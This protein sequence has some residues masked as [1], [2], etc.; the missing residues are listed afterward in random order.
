MEDNNFPLTTVEKSIPLTPVFT[1]NKQLDSNHKHNYLHVG[2][3]LICACGKKKLFLEPS[4]NQGVLTGTKSDGKSYSVRQSRMRYMFPGEW[5]KF[6]ATFTN[7]KHLL[8]FL[9]SIY[10]G[11][12][13]MEI[14]HLKPSSFNFERGTV[15]FKVIKQR[16]AKKQYYATKTG[17]QF[18]VSD[19]FL[20]KVK[21]Y[22]VKY[23]VDDNDYLFLPKDK[24]PPH[25]ET[26]TNAQKKKYYET[27][28][29]GYS[30]MFKR[31]LRKA[32]IKSPEEL[33]L[34]NLRKTYG[35]YMRA[36]GMALAE[37]C[38]RMG[39]DMDTFMAHYGSSLI[40]TREE[41]GMIQKMY[42][43]VR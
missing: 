20:K 23:K 2:D 27:T 41:I 3:Y 28:K 12:R 11:G 31:R 8:F 42:G 26:L 30:K 25:Y 18:F 40:F 22:V 13:V 38:Q 14:L 24:I 5:N 37:I 21:R 10:T 4:F 32:G 1:G 17:R 29:T 16:T 39:H 6:A 35:N 15:D 43:P 9:C 36:L 19:V 7:D 33:S 34:H